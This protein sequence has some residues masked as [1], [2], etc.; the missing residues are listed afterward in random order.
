MAKSLTPIQAHKLALDTLK[1]FEDKWNAYVKEEARQET[2]FD[3]KVY[4]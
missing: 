4:N 3:D 1:N 2:V